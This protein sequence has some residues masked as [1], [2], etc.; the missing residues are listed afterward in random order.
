M[1]ILMNDKVGD[2]MRRDQ[3]M[4]GS[5]K[6]FLCSRS[7]HHKLQAKEGFNGCDSGSN[8]VDMETLDDNMGTKIQVDI[9]IGDGIHKAL[10]MNL[11]NNQF[12]TKVVDQDL[13]SDTDMGHQV[14]LQCNE[15]AIHIQ[16]DEGFD[17]SDNITRSL[18]DADGVLMWAVLMDDL[19]SVLS[20]VGKDDGLGVEVNFG[21]DDDAGFGIDFRGYFGGDDVGVGG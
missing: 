19:T 6:T 1:G 4:D 5:K 10:E 18:G 13:E 20:N 7:E 11:L 8:D 15:Q 14:G 2:K 17:I 21:V 9:N 12:Q 3:E 16:L